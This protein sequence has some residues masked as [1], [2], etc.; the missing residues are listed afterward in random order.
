MLRRGHAARAR[1][2]VFPGAGG[3]DSGA[4]RNR[5][6]RFVAML[7]W[8]VL[9]SGVARAQDAGSAHAPSP[10]DVAPSNMASLK[11]VASEYRFRSDFYNPNDRQARA[12]NLLRTIDT[13]T[14][15]G[16]IH[17]PLLIDNIA[18]SNRRNG[19]QRA[20]I[21]LGLRSIKPD[22][23]VSNSTQEVDGLYIVSKTGVHGDSSGIL[24]DVGGMMHGSSFVNMIEGTASLYGRDNTISRRIRYQGPS[25]DQ[26]GGGSFGQQI[27]AEKGRSDHAIL[28]NGAS[29]SDY[30]DNFIYA[31]TAGVN[32]WRVD[33]MGNEVLSGSATASNVRLSPIRFDMLPICDARSAGTLAYIVD[34]NIPVTTWHQHIVA[35]RGANRAF[36]ACNGAGWFAFDY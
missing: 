20:S 30:F 4:R 36:V 11:Q 24:V 7:V 28:I 13:S 27:Y 15:D 35:G 14:E 2:A 10:Q 12:G 34:A 29:S 22:F 25:F 3:M 23:L 33:S 32:K 16:N 1:K 18:S 8:S 6:P 17:F 31:S 9:A 21:A 19:P 5:S 26:T